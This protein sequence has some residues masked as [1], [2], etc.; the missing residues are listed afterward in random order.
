MPTLTVRRETSEQQWLTVLGLCCD[1]DPA[2]NKVPTTPQ[3]RDGTDAHIDRTGCVCHVRRLHV[4]PYESR[5]PATT[6][7]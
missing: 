7:S 5:R 1:V 3:R 2:A 4:L 6:T